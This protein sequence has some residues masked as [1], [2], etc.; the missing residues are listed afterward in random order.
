MFQYF[1]KVSKEKKI[2][3]QKFKKKVASGERLSMCVF[4]LITVNFLMSFK[5]GYSNNIIIIILK[6]LSETLINNIN[7]RNPIHDNIKMY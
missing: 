3:S 6:I 4:C 5:K 7:A 2:N 1:L